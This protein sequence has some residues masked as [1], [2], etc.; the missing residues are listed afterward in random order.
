MNVKFRILFYQ[1]GGLLELPG[2][3]DDGPAAGAG[4]QQ[5]QVHTEPYD[6][7]EFFTIGLGPVPVYSAGLGSAAG[8]SLFEIL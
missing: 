4:P 6:D 8:T 5:H 1:D 2:Q 7:F 3:P